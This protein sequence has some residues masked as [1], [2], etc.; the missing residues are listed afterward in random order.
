MRIRACFACA[1]VCIAAACVLIALL[2]VN[3]LS[4]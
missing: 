2:M 1:V 3:F 4:S